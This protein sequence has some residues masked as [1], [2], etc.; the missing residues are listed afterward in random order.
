MSARTG[1]QLSIPFVIRVHL[2][3]KISSA[4]KYQPTGRHQWAAII[5]GSGVHSK[6]RIFS[7][8]NPPGIFSGVQAN[9][10]Q[11]APRRIHTRIA[12]RIE[13]PVITRESE[14]RRSGRLASGQ[15]LV[16]PDQHE[17]RQRIH[18]LGSQAWKAGHAACALPDDRRKTGRVTLRSDAN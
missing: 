7:E 10:V 15:H 2:A 17:A 16:F 6:F 8:R 12:F 5:F 1:V 18:L 11:R 4:D 14:S 9:R 13:E 3:I